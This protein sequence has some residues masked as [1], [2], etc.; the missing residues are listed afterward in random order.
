MKFCGVCGARLSKR[1]MACQECLN[2][3][4][5]FCS[6]CG[7]SLREA[8]PVPSA[9]LADERKQVTVLFADMRGSLEL[10]DGLDPEDVRRLLDPVLTLMINAVHRFEGTV[11]QVMGDGVMV[12]F[13][14]PLAYEDHALRACYAALEMQDAV[15]RFAVTTIKEHQVDIQI[16]IGINSGEVVVRS[17]AND[18]TLD[19]TA[20][21]QTT[22]LAARMEQIARP[23]TIVLTGVT[24]RLT[25]GYVDV[26]PLGPL[27][28]KGLQKPVEIFQLV[29]KRPARSRLLARSA[30]H[31]TR[32]AGRD[33]ELETMRQIF[34]GTAAGHGQ[35]L[36]V[37]GEPGVGKS[38]LIYEM[39]ISQATR[40]WLMLEAHGFPYTKDVAYLPIADIVKAYCRIEQ[41]D[42]LRR[43]GE[44][45]RRAVLGLDN[46]LGLII[47]A[48]L[49]LV[50]VPTADAEWEALG[51]TGR[52]RRILDSVAALLRR[53]SRN[54]PVCLVVEDLQ[55]IDFETQAVLNELV[56]RLS[57]A[58]L[59]LLV[60]YRTGYEHGW[61]RSVGFS[62]IGLR[63]LSAEKAD[64][65]LGNMVGPHE[66]L[67]PLRRRLVEKTGGNP[68]FLEEC[69]RSIVESDALVGERAAYQLAR[70]FQAERVPATVHA[71]LAARIDRLLAEDKVILEVA[72]AIGRI[73]P[74]RLLEA[75]TGS[76]AEG[77]HAAL[78][79]LQIAQ[80]LYETGQAPDLE[81][82]FQHALIHDVAYGT[83]THAKRTDLHARILQAI[84]TLAGDRQSDYV[85][86]LAHHARAGELWPRASDYLYQAGTKAFAH[87]ANREAVAWFEQALD[88]LRHLPESPQT[89]TRAVDLLLGLRN[90]LTLLGEHDRVLVHLAEAQTLA[91]RVGDQFRFGRVLSCQVN[92]L[93]LLGRHDAAIEVGHRARKV[94]AALDD[95]SLRIGTDQYVGRAHLYRG[96][97]SGAIEIFEGIVNTLRGARERDH[98]G[99]QALPSVF[100][101]SHLIEALAEMGRFA[102]SGRYCDEARALA[103]TTRHTDT[104]W[105]AL[106]ARGLH[107]F[108]KREIG[109]AIEAHE[110]AYELARAHDMP[111]YRARSGAELARAWSLEGRTAEALPLAATAMAEMTPRS[112]MITY[113]IILLLVGWVQR[114]AGAHGR[115]AEHAGQALSLF[116]Q[117]GERALEAHAIYL[118]GDIS[119]NQAKP[120]LSAGEV[121]YRSA[122]LLAEELGM[123]PLAARCKFKLGLLLRAS[124]RGD[125]A[126]QALRAAC[127]G[128]RDMGLGPEL[129]HSEAEL[130]ATP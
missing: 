8:I 86:Q 114:M 35:V 109:P 115:A 61:S 59:L 1:C 87:F 126:I 77:L 130:S 33:L 13:G 83:L 68:F 63:A 97:F 50:G 125:E 16:R 56:Q 51:A 94:S 80:L 15:R 106:H 113:A 21:G 31:L 112:Q 20:I 7:A 111:V 67:L 124:G 36:A 117:R 116:R 43:T 34:E 72:A 107:H 5:A 40:G 52:R 66:S 71:L 121:H 100:A 29:G 84:E 19:Y 85:E 73:V 89:L 118:L 30:Q 95:L 11:S 54:Q 101:R 81:Y 4:R 65:L 57:D 102:E 110:Q 44:K 69:V 88:A 12:I 47:P 96:D 60:S 78:G 58:R 22:H 49:A 2:L 82:A 3:G 90:S 127:D 37:V 105:W 55:W 23:G 26:F 64:E 18:R 9:A 93:T 17:I 123:R 120:D 41:A 99:L 48:L 75:V 76:P 24:Q 38:R 42:D 62:Q 104:L 129:S 108:A 103:A 14:A 128:Y 74:L 6:E 122:G 70:P 92:S 46:N 27:S 45:V 98:V 32:L 53:E 39:A 119:A 10:I 91:E 79:R 28:I 25:E